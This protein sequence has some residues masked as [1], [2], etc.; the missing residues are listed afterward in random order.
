MIFELLGAGKE[1][2][3]TG[4]ELATVLNCSVRDVTEQ[5]SRE[6]RAGRPICAS[7]DAKRPG[8]YIAENSADLVSYCASLKSRGIEIFKTRQ[9]LIKQIQA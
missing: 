7:T 5:I 4:K 3:R 1:N 2:A 8:Y 6:R 9:A